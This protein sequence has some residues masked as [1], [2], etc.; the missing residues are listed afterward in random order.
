MSAMVHQIRLPNLGQTSEEMSVV[1]WYKS[2]GDRVSVAEPLL[3]VETDKA[4]VDVESAEAGVL[5]QQFVQPGAEVRAGD[6]IALIGDGADQTPL[7]AEPA[8]D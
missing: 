2:P 7:S 3:C 1:S 8:D 6:L 5:L 4:E